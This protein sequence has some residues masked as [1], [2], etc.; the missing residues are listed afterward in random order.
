MRMLLITAIVSLA[1]ASLAPRLHAQQLSSD[2]RE[3]MGT[4]VN[5]YDFGQCSGAEVKRQEALLTTAWAKA[6][7]EMKDYGAEA[8]AALLTEQRAWIV[9][10]DASCKF[11]ITSDRAFGREGSVIH[12]G[13]CR[14]QVIS[15][16][17]TALNDLIESLKSR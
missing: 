6:Y 1:C 13:T 9:F 12:F 5:N 8:R 11:Y 16:R 3:C 17:V 7:G 2:Y 15:S 4:A 14:A 10:K